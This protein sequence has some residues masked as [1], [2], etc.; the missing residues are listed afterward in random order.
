MI[1]IL[2]RNPEQYARLLEVNPILK[3]K[4]KTTQENYEILKALNYHPSKIS[5]NLGRTL[6][7]LQQN[8][9]ELYDQLLEIKPILKP[10]SKKPSK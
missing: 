2:A 6:D 4:N 10:R 5:K 1:K 9:P 3:P 7:S 8:H